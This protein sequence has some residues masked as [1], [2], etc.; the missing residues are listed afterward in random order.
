LN[1]LA[2]EANTSFVRQVRASNSAIYATDRESQRLREDPISWTRYE[3]QLQREVEAARAVAT[4]ARLAVSAELQRQSAPRPHALG[5]SAK[6]EA[7]ATAQ[8]LARLRA[9]LELLGFYPPR[10]A[11]DQGKR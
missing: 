3:A 1:R 10:P 11:P 4:Q 5:P 7:E 8:R 2:D 9:D 6:A